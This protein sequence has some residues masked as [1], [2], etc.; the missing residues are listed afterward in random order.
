MMLRSEIGNG[1]RRQ[2]HLPIDADGLRILDGGEIERL[3]KASFPSIFEHRLHIA[4]ALFK[5][6]SISNKDQQ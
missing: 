5:I 3:S 1:A 6:C 2:Y 4:A